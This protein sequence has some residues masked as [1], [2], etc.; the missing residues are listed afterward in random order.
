MTIKMILAVG[1]AV[2]VLGSIA[3]VALNIAPGSY[4]KM[5]AAIAFFGEFVKTGMVAFILYRH[6]TPLYSRA[7]TPRFS[8]AI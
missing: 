5:D 3:V 6:T 7:K 2:V 8:C 1:I 4:G